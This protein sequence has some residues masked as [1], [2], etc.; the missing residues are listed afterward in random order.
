MLGQCCY[1]VL[2][3]HA[4]ISVKEFNQS[5]LEELLRLLSNSSVALLDQ[6]SD[7]LG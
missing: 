7:G 2:S 6:G 3:L 1:I 4:S 5:D